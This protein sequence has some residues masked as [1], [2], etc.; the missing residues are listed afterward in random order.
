MQIVHRLSKVQPASRSHVTIGVFDGVHRGHQR[1]IGEMVQTAHAANRV[2]VAITFDPHP[3]S[4][5][6]DEPQLLLTTVGERID[7]LTNLDLDALVVY[8]FTPETA[9]T[10]AADFVGKLIEHLQMAEL[11]VGPDFTLGQGGEGDIP[12]LKRLGEEEGFEVRAIEPVAW[13]GKPVHSSRIRN[14]LRNGDVAEAA[15]CLAR[16]YRLSGVVTHGHGVGKRI[17][18]PTA[19]I[20]PPTDRLI[21]TGGVYACRA[22]TERWGAYPAAVNI[23]TRPT[24]TET[25]SA[26]ALTIEAHLMDFDNNLYNQVLT[27]DFIAHLRDERVFSTLNALV[28]QLQDDI[29]QAR[30]LLQKR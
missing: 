10:S 17:G 24:F 12:A 29:A 30:A 21:P 9:Q 2:A 7:L 23:G 1:L 6:S 8:P 15:G 28:A 27:L 11:W 3:A 5:V 4:I 13:D 26:Q 16:P 19:N 25:F 22:H 14:A 18:V 20:A